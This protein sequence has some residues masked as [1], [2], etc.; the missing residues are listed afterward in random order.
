MKKR[1]V[2]A[3]LFFVLKRKNYAVFEGKAFKREIIENNPLKKHQ[4]LL[5][6]KINS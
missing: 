4:R 3:P 5:F 2:F 6:C 1:G